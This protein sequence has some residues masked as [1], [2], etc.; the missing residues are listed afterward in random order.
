MK[1]AVMLMILAAGIGF[2]STS[3]SAQQVIRRGDTCF[4]VLGQRIPCPPGVPD[5]TP[6]IPP[7][8]PPRAAGSVGAPE[9]GTFLLVGSGL[10]GLATWRR[11]Q[12]KA[13]LVQPPAA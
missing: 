10:I 6:R 3:A 7:G 11:K 1:S 4:N 12:A 2:L 8:N 13:R 5:R 9:P